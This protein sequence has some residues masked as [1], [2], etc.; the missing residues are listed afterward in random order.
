MPHS[1]FD[2]IV[3]GGG[4]NGAAV[5]RDAAHRG[6]AVLLL[7]KNDFGSGTSSWS[8]RL[9]HGG[10]RYLEYG[11]LP[12][13]YESLHDRQALLET[14]PHLVEPLRIG[15][16]IYTG[17]RRGRCLVRL[18]MI[19]YDLLSLRKTLPGHEMIGAREC[20]QRMPGL[21]ADGLQGAAL[22]YD[23]QV[24]YAERLVL[25]NVIDAVELGAVARN[26]CTVT[27]IHIDNAAVTGVGFTDAATGSSETATAPLV[28]N[29]GGP[30]VDDVLSGAGTT[31]FGDYVG[32]TKGSHIVVPH[33]DDAPPD[34]VYVEA[35]ADGRPIFIIPWNLQV[36][37]GTT[38]IRFDGDPAS[39]RA[40]LAEIDYLLGELN[41]L[42]PNAAMA[43][44]DISFTYSGV[45]PLPPQNDGPEGA[46]SR[47][48]HVRHH[49]H[50]ARG[51]YSVVGGKLTT[52]LSLAEDVLKRLNRDFDLGLSRQGVR[53]RP[54]PGAGQAA[55]DAGDGQHSRE[56]R[57]HLS[58]VYGARADAVVALAAGDRRLAEVV[59][60]W[61]GALAAEVV[62]ALRHEFARTL[63]DVLNRRLMI[64]L[65]PDIGLPALPAVA[66]VMAAELGWDER[67]RERRQRDYERYASERF[68]LH[69]AAD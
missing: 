17:A 14:A 34:A 67:E 27:E 66:R 59:C 63:D 39:A 32:G 42:F 23:G 16:P 33:F 2:L 62:H 30:W 12:L 52:F 4:I 28:V 43:R 45:R 5:A 11:E 54:F 10:L 53:E 6:L 58:A 31:A 40:S 47:K 61:S 38:D 35:G 55:A 36:L 65:N 50:V 49:N 60:P 1:E 57:R 51:L 29:A 20:L 48:H 46:I 41:R 56:T 15:I 26:Y 19:A 37:I 25:E 8:S 64:G 69:R 44:D 13:V 21:N 22:Y 7:D 9:I 24:T 3:V 18:G 68:L